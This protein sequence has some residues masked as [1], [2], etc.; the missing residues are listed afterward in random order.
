MR[1]MVDGN[2]RFERASAHAL[3]RRA[4]GGCQ[5]CIDMVYMKAYVSHRKERLV[6]E[7]EHAEDKEKQSEASEANANL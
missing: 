5:Q 3:R 2:L 7:K 6:E 1:W 4:Y